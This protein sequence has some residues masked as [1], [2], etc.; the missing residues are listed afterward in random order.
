MFLPPTLHYVERHLVLP[1]DF[2]IGVKDCSSGTVFRPR[3]ALVAA[4][5]HGDSMIG[6]RFSD[7]D[8]VI[9][10]C[11]RFGDL[12]RERI[13]VIEKLGGDENYCSWALKKIVIERPSSS[14]G[15]ECGHERDWNDPIIRLYSYNRTI[16][17]WQLDPRG[18]YRVHGVFRR[19]VPA[20]EASFESSDVIRRKV[21]GHD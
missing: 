3:Q 14:G 17:P 18:D 1:P 11:E 10:Q 6:A 13:V 2:R 12:D 19:A 21:T 5:I 7:G 16:E 20:K 4:E 8:I 9:F 15:V